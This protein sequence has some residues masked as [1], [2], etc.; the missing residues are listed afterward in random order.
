MSTRRW[1]DWVNVI[2]G[3]WLAASAW[4]F[5]LNAGDGPIVWSSW[6]AGGAIVALAAFSMYK[7]SVRADALGVM[8]GI[9]LMVSPWMLGLSHLS[10]AAMNAIIM[11]LLVVGYAL[12]ALRID[13]RIS[14]DWPTDIAYATPPERGAARN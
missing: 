6:S 11:G 7:P 8:V 14:R 1:I 4:V 13:T 12:W 5:V 10:S 9:W 2:L 3:L